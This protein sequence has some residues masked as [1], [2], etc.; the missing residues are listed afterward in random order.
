MNQKSKFD[1]NSI[2]DNQDFINWII[3]PEKKSSYDWEQIIA[4]HPDKKE[5]DKVF[6]V[7][8]NLQKEG[9]S[10]DQHSVSHLWKRIEK[11]SIGKKKIN[12]FAR[13]VAAASVIL[14]LSIGGVLLYQ[15]KFSNSSGIDYHSI[16]RVE[17][18][19][20]EVKLI[21]SDQSEKLLKSNDAEIKYDKDGKIEINETESISDEEIDKAAKKEQL[22]QLVVPL[23]KR[24]SLTLS[25]GTVLYLN[26]GS[27]AIYPVVFTRKE[28][29]IYVEGEA[30]LEVAHDSEKPF[31]VVTNHLKVRVLGTTFNVSA[32]P[33]D[34]NT[35]VV[36]V[37][38]S[39]ETLF[40][41]EKVLMKE[42]QLFTHENSTGKTSL[43][44]ANVLDYISWKDGWMYCNQKKMEDITT[45]L[46]RYYDVTI[47]YKDDNVKDMTITGK[48]DLKNNCEDVFKVIQSTAPI[49][50]EINNGTFILSEKL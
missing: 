17:P 19:G 42:N 8:K 6:W 38:G 14:V 31:F 13:W 26:S 9:R 18:T 45:K 7:V 36:L 40:S 10:L 35:S 50:Y 3:H 2:I 28:R 43:K 44:E 46:S 12:Y 27:R 22:N 4:D 39:V 25:D 23:G 24:S 5:I 30:F 11:Q 41:S 47:K 32:Y 29:E 21:L 1:I 34:S 16:A 49:K 33:D 48:L 15:L 37:E 20:N